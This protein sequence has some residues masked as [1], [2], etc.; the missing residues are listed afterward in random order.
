MSMLHQRPTKNCGAA[1]AAMA[2]LLLMSGCQSAGRSGPDGAPSGATASESA[3]RDAIGG[4]S[5]TL[6]VHGMSCPLCAH[7]VE[8]QLR[9][10]PGVT[11]VTLDL[12]TG[13][14]TVTLDGSG[15]T[16]RRMLAE[17]IQRSGFTLKE[18]RRL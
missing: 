9:G 1:A 7:N 2:L 8:R 15:R 16:T 14:A 11:G 10:V 6:V 12:S 13:E 3:L 5:A 4:L 18:V 17:A